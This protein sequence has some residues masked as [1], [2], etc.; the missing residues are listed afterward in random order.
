MSAQI[1]IIGNLTR[2]PELK[3]LGN[4]STVVK[5]SVAVNRRVKGKNGEFTESTSFFNVGAFGTLAENTADSLHQGNRVIVTGRIEQRTWDKEDGT[6][7]TAVEIVAEA[8]GPDLRWN[9]ADVKLGRGGKS[10]AT[11]GNTTPYT[12]ED[13]F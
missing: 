6:K 2:D 10:P 1:T 8:I 12:G 7:G 11:K 9:N 13:A 3:F 4:D 5:L